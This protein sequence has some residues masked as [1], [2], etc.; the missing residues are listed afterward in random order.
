MDL[1]EYQIKARSTAIYLDIPKSKILYPALGLMGECGEVIEKVKKLIRDDNWNMTPERALATAKEL[2]DCC[3]YLANICCD[4]DL[5]LKMMYEMRGVYI[6]QQI[7]TLSLPRLVFH[8]NKHVTGIAEALKYLYYYDKH[9]RGKKYQYPGLPNHL[10][11]VIVCIE[12][13]AVK[14]GLTLEEICVANIEK[15]A[16]RK[17]EGM[18][19]G[20]GDTR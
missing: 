3:W 8:M 6:T 19:R 16:K 2:G 12:E 14:C 11:H 7:R 13:I 1:H 18:L 4:I 15:L 10:T 5:D 20:D 9:P 17:Q